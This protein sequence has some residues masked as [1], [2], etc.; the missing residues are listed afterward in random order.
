MKAV[1]SLAFALVCAIAPAVCAQ[2]RPQAYTGATIIPINGPPIQDGVLVVSRGK[3]IAVGP[4]ASTQIP[5]DAQTID[6]SGKVIMPGLVDSHSHIGG[7]AGGDNSAPIQ[8]DV[9]ILDSINVQDNSLRR[10]RAGGI[11]TVNVMPG[12]SLLL[13]GQTLYL[14]LRQGKVIDDLLIRDAQGHIAGGMKMANGTNPLRPDSSGPLP[15]TRARSAALVREQ[16]VKAQEYRERVRRAGSDRSKMPARDLAMEALVEV[17]EGRRTVHFHTH[18]HDDILTA[19]RLA[20]EFGFRLVLHHVSEGWKVAAEI[21]RAQVPTSL[22]VVDA[23]GGKLESTDVTLGNGM[24]LD[25]AGVL[26]GFNTDDYIT[27]SRL[28]LRAAALSVRAGMTRERA[29]YAMTLAGARM[30]GLQDRTGSLEP[31]KDADFIIL[32]G[33]PFSVY[34]HVLETY[35]EGAKVFDRANPDD[36]LYATG[37]QGAGRGQ[38]LDL[39]EIERTGAEDGQ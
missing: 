5:A 16:F 32:S 28:F 20:K 17:L 8:P 19:M 27:D 13:S 30:L 26:V 35:V 29:L 6:A 33:D 7:G 31:G 38:L 12:S 23:P 21:A 3:I 34:T 14:K 10:A 36:R 37:G 24:L 9:R 15:G 4:R 2:D 11:T 18:R 22:T 39:D 1:L 25:R